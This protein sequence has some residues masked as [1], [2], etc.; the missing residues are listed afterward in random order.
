MF[1]LYKPNF[2][3]VFGTLCHSYALYL[4]YCSG[5]CSF[6]VFFIGSENERDTIDGILSC[7]K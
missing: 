5:R 4:H 7:G 6:V 1:S 2:C 3:L